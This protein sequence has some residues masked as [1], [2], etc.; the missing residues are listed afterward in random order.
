MFLSTKTHFQASEAAAKIKLFTFILGERFERY[1]RYGNLI[2]GS[3]GILNR[4]Q[5]LE[6]TTLNGTLTVRN[7]STDSVFSNSKLN[8]I[9]RRLLMLQRKI[10]LMLRLLAKDECTSNPCKH[11]A[12][13]RDLFNG[14]LC[15]CPP[16]WEVMWLDY[17]KFKLIKLML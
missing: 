6:R 5:T 13:C 16:E 12:T 10:N 3:D 17:K 1:D 8:R 14:F 11:G 4:L 2:E 15:H 9:N 7:N